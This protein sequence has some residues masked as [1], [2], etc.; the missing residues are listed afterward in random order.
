M[1]D[2]IVAS[3]FWLKKPAQIQA[4]ESPMRQEIFDAFTLKGPSSISEI[5][6]H[7]GRSPDSLYFHI[8]KLLKVGILREKETVKSGR[9]EWVIYEV[10]GRDG[11]LVYER[12]SA[13]SI[14]RV[15]SGACRLSL[16]EFKEAIL[17]PT[18]VLQGSGRTV[19]G[20]RVKGWLT[21]QD[22]EEVNRHMEKIVE[23]FH[24]R[25][26]SQGAEVQTFGWVLCP[27]K[28]RTRR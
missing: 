19:W 26:T 18:A 11:R 20:G 17:S 22:V 12:K 7:L 3:T 13:S 27:A 1:T 10:P 15:V 5:A 24:R 4:L 6:S 28:K 14:T 2:R 21:E 23:I 9:N 16:R 25:T 8:K